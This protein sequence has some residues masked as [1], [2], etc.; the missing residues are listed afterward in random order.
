[1]RPLPITTIFAGLLGAMFHLLL[2]QESFSRKAGP[3]RVLSRTPA[4]AAASPAE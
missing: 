3:R 2:F 4:P 1:M